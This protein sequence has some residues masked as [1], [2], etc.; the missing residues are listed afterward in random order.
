MNPNS[1]KFGRATSFRVPLVVA[2]KLEL[3]S[4][5]RNDQMREEALEMFRKLDVDNDGEITIKDAAS[6]FKSMKD[7]FD[8]MGVHLKD[9]YFK[10]MVADMDEDGSGSVSPSS[11]LNE[12]LT[13]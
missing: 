3:T 1:A 9:D 10:N 11:T 6:Y 13:N 8:K 5:E 7:A 12:D 2:R 4:T